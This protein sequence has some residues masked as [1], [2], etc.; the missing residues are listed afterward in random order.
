MKNLMGRHGT[1]KMK[2]HERMVRLPFFNE[3]IR[4]PCHHFHHCLE[5]LLTDPRRTD[6]HYTFFNDDPMAGPSESDAIGDLN[7]GQAYKDTYEVL[8]NA[9]KGAQLLGIIFYVDGAATGL[10]ADL[11]VTIVKF[12]LSIFTNEAR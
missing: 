10:F 12:S 11:P 5:A 4:I 7:T 2:S 9:G 1:D 8:I 6:Y 3:V